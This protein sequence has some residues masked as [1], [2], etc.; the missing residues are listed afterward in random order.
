MDVSES[1]IGG[2]YHIQYTVYVKAIPFFR[3]NFYGFMVQYLHF[4]LQK[5]PLNPYKSV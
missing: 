1:Q 3:P 5:F 2:T 4:R